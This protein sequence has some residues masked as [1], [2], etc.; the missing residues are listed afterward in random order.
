MKDQVVESVAEIISTNSDELPGP[1]SQDQVVESVAEIVSPNSDDF[2]GAESQVVLAGPLKNEPFT[3]LTTAEK[4]QYKY[5]MGPMDD[6][7]PMGTVSVIDDEMCRFG[8]DF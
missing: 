2:T 8:A 3:G 5:V 1:E 7:C 4:M 6:F